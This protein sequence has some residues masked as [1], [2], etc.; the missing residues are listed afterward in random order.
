MA[1]IEEAMKVGQSIDLIVQ[2]FLGTNFGALH[3][4]SISLAHA[5]F[6]LAASPEYAQ[7]LRDE[8]EGIVK[9]DGWTK[10][11][12]GKMWK[13]DSF[14]KESQ[15]VNGVGAMAILRKAAVDVTLSDGTHVP[16]GTF[17]VA[18]ASA[19]HRDK[20][21]YDDPDSFRPFRFS[22]M[23]AAAGE[24]VKHQFV[25][26]SP[27]YIPFG[28]GKHACPGRFFATN[29]LKVALACILVN[30]DVKFEDEGNRPENMWYGT[31][32]LPS[33]TAQVLFRKRQDHRV[34]GENE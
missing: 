22:D 13:L 16:A 29:V 24:Q 4:S 26:T 9:Q 11:A 30:Y 15:R 20:D 2:A 18:S 27:E 17:V 32:I 28:H 7:P 3:T 5:L 31:A 10:L 19:T 21:C 23:R 33:R 1:H 6:H 25:T 34:Q 14:M 8:I 12:F